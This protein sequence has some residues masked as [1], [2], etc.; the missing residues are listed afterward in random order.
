MNKLLKL[1]GVFAALS[2]LLSGCDGRVVRS[3]QEEQTTPKTIVYQSILH[4]P[5]TDAAVI[6]FVTSNHC[7]SVDHFQFCKEIGVAL[8]IDANQVVET[9]YLYVN[10][11][12]DVQPYKGELPYG[13]KFYDTLGA[14]EYRL[15]KQAVGNAGL[16]DEGSSPDHLHYWA[17]Y[18]EVG[19][20]II[21]NSP[22][23]DED[24]TIYAILVSD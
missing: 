18:K 16:P 15:K 1:L 20:T 23:A 10:G 9:V 14:V 4:K 12:E 8:W 17:T 2:L 13:L 6:D 11:E 19:M 3:A 24:A 22:Y 21:Y 5:V 7:A